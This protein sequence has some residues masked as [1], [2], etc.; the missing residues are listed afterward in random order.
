MRTK[1]QQTHLVIVALVGIAAVAAV[2]RWA[3]TVEPRQEAGQMRQ[4]ATLC[5]RWFDAVAEMK[6]ERGISSDSRSRARYSA[7]IGDDFT[8][9]T[10]T[11]GSLEAKETAA[12]PDF[13]AL[14]VRLYREA[15]IDSANT[16][17]IMLS[18]SFPSLAIAALAATQTMGV[19][20]GGGSSLGE[21]T[22]GANQPDATWIDMERWLQATAGLRHASSLVTAG[23]QDDNGSGLS[24][25]GMADIRAATDRCAVALYAPA[26][27]DEAI[28]AKVQLFERADIDLLVNVG[29]NQAALGRCPQS[30]AIP[31]GL[32]TDW[33][34]SDHPQ[35][36]VIA[37]LAERGVPFIHL[38]NI[39]D[40]AARYQLPIAPGEDLA[41][42][43]ALYET[44]R[45]HT[46]GPLL[47]LGL[48]GLLLCGFSP[49]G[50]R[51]VCT[52]FARNGRDAHEAR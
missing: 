44:R 43:S 16:V 27:L 15:G 42:V 50:Q 5:A 30:D 40:L 14:L 9:M 11:L 2:E 29:G 18:G 6:A 20:A 8:V 51:L 39:K 26:S 17:G 47:G 13:A 28:A 33:Q 46:A 10:T 48:T 34:P 41:E 21:S 31:N 22:Y 32:Q 1:W 36:G 52:L 19:D 38:L 3:V 49:R 24:E 37:R 7:L 4:A 23:A 35:R 12:N 25:E 45:V